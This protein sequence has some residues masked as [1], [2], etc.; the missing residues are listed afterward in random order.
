MKTKVFSLFLFIISISFAQI[1]TSGLTHEYL[2]TNGSYNTTVGS[3]NLTQSGGTIATVADREGAPTNAIEL[4]NSFLFTPQVAPTNRAS[5]SF[6]IKTNTND[7]FDRAIIDYHKRNARI[8]TSTEIGFFLALDEGKIDLNANYRYGYNFMQ[9]SESTFYTGAHGFRSNAFVADNDW[10]HIVLTID[11][12]ALNGNIHYEYNLYIDGVLDNTLTRTSTPPAQSGQIYGQLST[13]ERI[14]AGNNRNGN[15]ISDRVYG[16]AIDD[17]RRYT[18]TLSSAEVN[19]LYND[20]DSCIPTQ[21][22]ATDVQSSSVDL[23]WMATPDQTSWDVSYTTSGGNPST[24]TIVSNVGASPYTLNGLLPTTAYDIYVRSTCNGILSGWSDVASITTTAVQEII[25]VDIDATGANDGSSWANAYT[26]LNDAL[27]GIPVGTERAIWIA[28]GTYTPTTTNADPRMA[29]FTVPTLVKIYGG[30]NGTETMLS[31]RDP[32]INITKLSGDLQGNDNGTLTTT[33]TTRTDNAYHIISL[34]EDM[35]DVVVDGL[36]ISDANPSGG[37]TFTGNVANRINNGTG[38]AVYVALV[39]TAERV[40]AKFNN[41]ILENN[42]GDNGAV[43][44]TYIQN[45]NASVSYQVD[46]TNSKIRSN[47]SRLAPIMLYYGQNGATISG[48]IVNSVFTNNTT[49]TSRNTGSC[50]G[51]GRVNGSASVVQVDVINST[52]T[53]NSAQSGQVITASG[54]AELSTIS[55]CIIYGNGSSTPLQFV[56][57]P[58]PPVNNS[59]VEGGQQGGTNLD[60]LFTSATDFTLQ[61]NSPAINAGNNS[62]L[63]VD[64]TEDIDGNQRIFDT[65]VDMGA[66]EFTANCGEFFNITL[67]PS[68]TVATE[69]TLTWNHPFDSGDTFDVVYV[70]SGMPIGSGTT[71]NGIS[72]NSQLLTGLS[73]NFY[74]IYLRANCSGSP[75]AY[76]LHTLGFKVPIFV[77]ASATGADNGSGWTNAYTSLETA[78]TV[79]SND[80][81]IWVAAGTY[82]PA[83]TSRLNSFMITNDNL[84]IYGGFN[85]TETQLSQRDFR[86][87]ETILSGDVN[88]DD[89]VVTFSGG[90]RNENLYHVV[91]VTG[92]SLTLDGIVISG[93]QATA[94]SG[95]DRFGAGIYKD[96]GVDNLVVTNSK[97]RNN[98]SIGG[99]SIFARC[100]NGE[101]ISVL[102]S[103]FHD[104]LGTYAAGLYAINGNNVSYTVT[105]ANSLFYN[106]TTRN[107]GSNLGF[108]GSSVWLRA[109]GTSSSLTSTVTNCT[110]V[111]NTDIGTRASTNRGTFSASRSGTA[112][113]TVVVSN[114]VFYGN[115]GANNAVT[116]VIT[117]GHT[118]IANSITVNNAID[119]NNFVGV[120]AGS[121][122]NTSNANPLFTDAANGDY[123]L[124]ASSPAIN[125]GNNTFVIGTTDVA[126]N[127]RVEDTTVDIGAYEYAAATSVLLSPRV[128][129]Q[130]P[131]LGGNAIMN[132]DLRAGNDLPTTSPY[133]DGATCDAAVFT[134]T[135]NDAIIDWIWVELRDVTTNTIILDSQ[136]ALLQRDGDVVAVDG[137]SSLLFNQSVGSYYV[138]LKHR[139]HLGVMTNNTIS[140]SG[141]TAIVDFTDANNQITFGSNSQTTFGMPSGIT[142]MWAGN[143]NGDDIVQYSGTTPDTPSI[144]SQVLNDAGNFLNFPTYISE[145]YNVHDINMDGNTQY[146]GTTPD[147]PLILQNV[148]AHPGN[149]LNFS[150]YQIQEQLPEN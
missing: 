150:T 44:G 84:T 131:M 8:P 129:L 48:Q 139:N 28:D 35:T 123:T 72:G 97:F 10:H 77:N 79:A 2:F 68:A 70:V 89:T 128:F 116:R 86:A 133:A 134:V 117:N 21:L 67:T 135:G 46:F 31:Q 75:S 82:K 25:Y 114:S 3:D 103:I 66:Y 4:N 130:G 36:T 71:I 148:L 15:L 17:I 33:E 40:E 39:N 27:S 65:T 12:G 30:F 105:L 47:Y 141:T 57:A 41:C 7:T 13:L 32:A 80:D 59:I 132:D 55:N 113:H 100:A 142:A 140:L 136:S 108:T 1:P 149:F 146:T 11:N 76:E 143:V 124:T 38:G 122:T 81:V 85:G 115:R 112:N 9:A 96:V 120:P 95:D 20:A 74:D 63:P 58:F 107:S 69:A 104:N 52:F 56:T 145:G 91:E 42:T 64:I 126:N 62:F 16:D 118:I 54:A 51:I 34:R 147:T 6:W 99:S 14:T 137:T 144:L 73:S 93:G 102:N 83:G 125:A 18:R 53:N 109:N 50:L 90:G 24:G 19:A 78:L 119:E 110:F 60:P 29:T 22:T 45:G 88:D 106:N 5:I 101:T 92:Q 26:G 43:F 121:Q 87:N 98:V 23:S 138:V 127:N 94:S 37:G 49:P 61:L 111:D